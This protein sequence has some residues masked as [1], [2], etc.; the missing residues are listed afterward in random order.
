[1]SEN[2]M[3]ATNAVPLLS[4]EVE[5]SV[6]FY[7]LDPLNIVWH[8]N[9]YKYFEAARAELMRSIGFDIEQMRQSG[10]AWPVSK[11]DCTYVSPL[12]YDMKIKVKAEL[13]EEAHRLGLRYT[14]TEKETGKILA[15]GHT[16]Q[17]AVHGDS[18]EMCLVTP[19]VLLQRLSDARK[20]L[21]S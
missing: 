2:L 10:Y 12:R 17:V 16:Q 3:D 8:G 14:I 6:P 11:S 4:A 5:M 1:M 15:R 9:Y 18:W 20:K 7:D 19:D 21:R 13:E